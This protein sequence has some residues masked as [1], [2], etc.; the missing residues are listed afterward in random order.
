MKRK[1]VIT[2][3]LFTFLFV[4]CTPATTTVPIETVASTSIFT[5]T[6]LVSIQ[7]PELS[8]PT[9]GNSYPPCAP[10]YK[11]PFP[12]SAPVLQI[13]LPS[14][15]TLKEYQG[16]P[17][18]D[19]SESGCRYE[20]RDRVHTTEININS[21]FHIINESSQN[22]KEEVVVLNNGEEVFIC[23]CTF[24]SLQEA[25]SYDGHWV[26]EFVTDDYLMK[27]NSVR[28]HVDVV[29]D[30][31]S[32]KKERNYKEVFAFQLLAG[33]PFYFFK[34]HDNTFGVNFDGNEIELSYDD[35]RYDNPLAVFGLDLSIF[36]YQNMV[37]FSA[38]KDGVWR[39]VVIGVFE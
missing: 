13:G 10:P 24:T 18:I 1:S 7:T 33:K 8:S 29:R 15:L 26:I 36:Q 17:D 6:P 27:D 35:I 11:S 2:I 28:Q 30:G 9:L 12:I 31:I 20:F 19:E 5:S 39:S 23:Q 4:A 32:L 16:E 22:S 37:K 25:W 3:S 34:K 38:E 21:S 14:D